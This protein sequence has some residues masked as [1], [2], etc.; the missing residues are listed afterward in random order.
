MQITFSVI[1]FRFLS[2]VVRGVGYWLSRLQDVRECLR[3]R[4]E[5]VLS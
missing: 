1:V 2:P 3:F 5:T 4:V